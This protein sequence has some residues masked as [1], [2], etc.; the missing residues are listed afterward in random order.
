M[1]E[2]PIKRRRP[3]G[4]RGMCSCGSGKDRYPLYD[5][6]GIFLTY[7]CHDCEKQRLSHYRP[8]IME[9]YECDEPIDED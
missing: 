3:D 2:I 6:Y 1:I 9:R 8:D 4:K 7:A 5:G